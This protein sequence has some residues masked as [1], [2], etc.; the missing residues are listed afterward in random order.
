MPCFKLPQL[1]V[2]KVKLVKGRPYLSY[3][4]VLV[5]KMGRFLKNRTCERCPVGHRSI[6]AL[7]PSALNS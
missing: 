3:I 1:P 6:A 5:L 2:R 4:T 7:L